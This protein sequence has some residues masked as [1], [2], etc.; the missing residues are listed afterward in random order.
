MSR[1]ADSP[2][3]PS[4][5]VQ[6]NLREGGVRQKGT[7][8]V[9]VHGTR[10]RTVLVLVVTVTPVPVLGTVLPH[11]RN[12]QNPRKRHHHQTARRQSVL[13]M[14]LLKSDE[15][16]AAVVWKLQNLGKLLWGKKGVRKV[17][18]TV[19]DGVVGKIAKNKGKKIA[20]KT[21]T[22][23]SERKGTVSELVTDIKNVVE[24]GIGTGVGVGGVGVAIVIGVEV[25]KGEVGVGKGEVEVE[26]EI[27]TEDV[28]VVMTGIGTGMTAE[29]VVV[30]GKGGIGGAAGIVISMKGAGVTTEVI[31]TIV[32]VIVNP[33]KSPPRNDGDQT[34][35][36]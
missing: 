28:V 8:M 32:L 10:H 33:A 6:G 34:P 5:R 30:V 35:N 22:D 23:Q 27:G 12:R 11:H 1:N 25:G 31:A 20:I 7:V 26:T 29:V 14:V 17:K 18:G 13:V 4:L 19:G 16:V 36:L 2:R 21:R 3:H 24:V 15:K 9:Q